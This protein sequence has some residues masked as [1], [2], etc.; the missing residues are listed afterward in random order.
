MKEFRLGVLFVHGI[1]TQPPRDTLVRWGDVLLKVIGRA[2]GQQPGR[3][4]PIIGRAEAGDRY[5]DKPAEVAVK[6]RCNDRDQS[7]K[8]L[9]AEGRW[10][11]S[12]P[13][14]S[15][16][17]LVS[18]SFR[19][20]PWAIALHVAQS[21]WQTNP[22]A[23]KGA[24]LWADAKAIGKLLGAMALTP[25]FVIL[26]ASTLVLGLLPIPQ[27]RSLILSTQTV[28]IGTI[29][30]SLAFVE[31]PLRAALIRGR[32]LEGL[33]RLKDRC[34]RT[35]IVAHSQGA[36]ATLHALGGILDYDEAGESPASPP[37]RPVP[38]ALVT[39][40]SGVN[41]LVS[42]K[43]ASAGRLGRKTGITPTLLAVM[44]LVMVGLFILLFAS[45][46]SGAT[47]IWPLVIT[48]IVLAGIIG[49][50]RLARWV[51]GQMKDT[52]VAW[53]VQ[54]VWQNRFGKLGLGFVF[55]AVII[56]SRFREYFDF[57]SER[58]VFAVAEA[59]F[60][61]AVLLW[62]SMLEI[63][64]SATKTAVTKPLRYPPGLSSWMDVYASAD[65][66]PNG[67]TRIEGTSAKVT[68]VKVWNRGSF[69]SDH[70]AY[71][72]NLDGFVLRVA[73]VCAETAES[74]WQDKL[75]PATQALWLDRRAVRRVRVL[76]WTVLYNW[77]LWAFLWWVLWKRY[78]ARVPTLFSLPS[79]FWDGGLTV[80]RLIVFTGLVAL[81]AWVTAGILRWRWSVWVRADQEAVLEQR[82]PELM[83]EQFDPFSGQGW[84]VTLLG[85]LALA[86]AFGLES[87]ANARLLDLK[88]W[89]SVP[90]FMML[91]WVIGVSIS[92][93][94]NWAF[95]APQPPY[96]DGM[97][98]G[99]PSP[100]PTIPSQG[101]LPQSKA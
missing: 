49:V 2:T 80:E 99:I 35:V 3:T 7:E 37:E 62:Y 68:S 52:R 48:F 20:V 44:T 91:T 4:I 43:V 67:P 16:A 92:Q 101:S 71:W 94:A 64:S 78:G 18:W 5:G 23:S 45:V 73:R 86:L 97:N 10:A 47:T 25:V 56:S 76:W 29:G 100:H 81:A 38:D 79:W 24:W 34:E 83:A 55:T 8:W 39:F 22:E 15:Y 77:L 66:V 21:Y 95:P 12:F 61:V 40:G 82:T 14:P 69:L 27:L 19:A 30:D 93:F 54:R 31:S 60:A 6:F 9:L 17:E 84:V 70:T 72:E 59:F 65:L 36:A 41:Q 57:L 1:G 87:D 28:L 96:V 11:D 50:A 88:F 26:L 53:G 85:S 13:A 33:E 42:L 51:G 98:V 89:W 90:V 74:P 46:R 75:P 63:L 32:I 58:P